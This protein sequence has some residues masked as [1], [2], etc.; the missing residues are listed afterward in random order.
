MVVT[1]MDSQFRNLL[2][3]DFLRIDAT[4]MEGTARRPTER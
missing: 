1:L 2:L 3:T 4:R